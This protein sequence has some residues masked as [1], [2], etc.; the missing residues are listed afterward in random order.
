[1]YMNAN[2][3]WTRVHVC[4]YVILETHLLLLEQFD[5][6]IKSLLM[7]DE[8]ISHSPHLAIEWHITLFQDAEEVVGG[9]LG[10]EV[11]TY[12]YIFLLSLIHI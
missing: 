11:L 10:E 6:H 5:E 1:M 3:I 2:V 9:C 8:V 12:M 7:N 4:V